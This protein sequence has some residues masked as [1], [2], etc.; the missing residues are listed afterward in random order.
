MSYQP[1]P[2][3]RSWL[4]VPGAQERYVSK[5]AE[6][7]PDAVVLDLED[8]VAPAE[9]PGARER[10]RALTHGQGGDR[11]LPPVV[12]VRAHGASREELDADVACLGPLVGVLVLPKVGGAAD[13][14][15]AALRLER[16]GLGHVG[17]VPTVES[18]A[19]LARLEEVLEH[20]KV[21]GVAFGAEDFAADVGLPATLPGAAP[22]HPDRHDGRALVLDQARA[23][24]VTA[25]AAAGVAW[26][27]DSPTLQL[28][29]ERLVEEAARRSRSLGFTA[30]F[31]IHPDHVAALHAGFRP[32]DA[33][34]A[35]ARSVLGA[36]GPGAG[37]TAVDGRMVDEAV[38]RQARAVLGAA[39]E[40]E[41]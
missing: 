13:V 5:L 41:G 25:A 6:V 35:W 28:R 34:V 2:P 38:L 26:R 18:A 40:R 33:E 32:S 22:P 9:L 16:A 20:P 8:G 23:R 19:G 3:P 31:A 4:F 36:A 14:A 27:V 7:R 15:V 1:T 10:V 24:I 29:P 17:V 21:V 39:G 37:A 30:R 12:A 11:W